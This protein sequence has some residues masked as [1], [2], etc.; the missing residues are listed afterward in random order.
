MTGLI[1][2]I[3]SPFESVS[4]LSYIKYSLYDDEL[5]PSPS[6]R[7]EF[8]TLTVRRHPEGSGFTFVLGCQ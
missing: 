8:S 4:L 3:V 2:N 5:A 7:I 6:E 1:E